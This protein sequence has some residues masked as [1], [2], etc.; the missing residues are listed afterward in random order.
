MYMYCPA[1]SSCQLDIRQPKLWRSYST[2]SITLPLE[3]HR[4]RLEI[5]DFRWRLKNNLG[6]CGT[7]WICRSYDVRIQAEN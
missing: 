1:K 2:L 4:C 6:F 7:G 3:N 5:Q